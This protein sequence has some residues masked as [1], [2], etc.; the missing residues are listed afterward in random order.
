LGWFFSSY[1][2][3]CSASHLFTIS[4]VLSFIPLWKKTTFSISSSSTPSALPLRFRA[5]KNI[6]GEG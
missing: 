1:S 3:W 5:L 2:A 6:C 4:H